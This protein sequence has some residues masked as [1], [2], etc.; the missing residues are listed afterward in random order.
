MENAGF[1]DIKVDFRSFKEQGITDR[2]PSKHL[3]ADVVNLER[4][5]IKIN[6]LMNQNLKAKKGK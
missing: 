6:C 5:K 4:K 1:N 2:Q 3:G